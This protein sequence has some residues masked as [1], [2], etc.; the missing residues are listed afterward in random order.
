[1]AGDVIG[2]LLRVSP[3]KKSASSVGDIEAVEDPAG[4]GGA[5][6]VSGSIGG[7]ETTQGFSA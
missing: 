4:E 5:T 7:R 2:V 6:K 1:M 3:S